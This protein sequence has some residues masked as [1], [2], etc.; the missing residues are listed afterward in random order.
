MEV[1]LVSIILII[2]GLTIAISGY[3]LFRIMLPV[4]GFIAG[5]SLGF[6]MIQALA[7]SNAFS[8]VAALLTAFLFGIVMAGLS[9]VYYTLGVMLIMSSL[10]AGLFAYLGEAVGL[11]ENGFVVGLL[12]ITGAVVGIITVLRYKLQ[13]DLIVAL[14]AM[15]GV[16]MILVGAFLIVGDFTLGDL[17]NDGIAR[18]ITSVVSSSWIWIIVWLAGTVIAMQTQIIMIAKAIFGDQFVLETSKKAGR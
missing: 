1:I 4:M 11:R 10:T 7:G 8:F 15:F 6:T 2:L 9:Y 14:T 13:H 16:G 3:S 18:S 17:H 5:F 12:G